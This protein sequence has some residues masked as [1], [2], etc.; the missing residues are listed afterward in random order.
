LNQIARLQTFADLVGFVCES[1]E[2]LI[3]SINYQVTESDNP[4]SAPST[5]TKIERSDQVR[6][7]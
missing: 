2:Y 5:G 6:D 3:V 7:R 1:S 4:L